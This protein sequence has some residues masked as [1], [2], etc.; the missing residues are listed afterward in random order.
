MKRETLLLTG[1]R[2]LTP[3]VFELTFS[4]ASAMRAGQFVELEV[5]GQ[6][7]R[8][9]I[10]VCD[11]ADGTLTLLVKRVGVGTRRRRHRLR[12][13]VQARPRFCGEGRASHCRA[14]LPGGGGNLL[15]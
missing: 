10:S 11:S 3:T 13:A 2:P 8:R 12:A 14:R 6:Y 7:L 4:G 5:E 9:P 1:N 15:P